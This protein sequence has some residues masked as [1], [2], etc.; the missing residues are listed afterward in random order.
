MEQTFS[1]ILC[2]RVY[3]SDFQKENTMTAELKQQVKTISTYE[4]SGNNSMTDDLFD[5]SSKRTYENVETRVAWINIPSNA[6]KEQVQKKLNAT[7]NAR[8]YKVLSNH[9]IL[10]DS[11][12]WAIGENLRTME[13]FADSQIV[14]Y[15]ANHEN[16]G[17]IVL[18]PNNKYQYRRIGFSMQGA[19]DQD[20]RNADISDQFIPEKSKEAILNSF[21]F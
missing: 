3:K 12:K 2:T 18:D 1:Q 21:E 10:T 9:P 13:E 16:A 20:L 15:P 6:T 7:P 5:M 17:E 14:R 11:D 8:L 4:V 19:E